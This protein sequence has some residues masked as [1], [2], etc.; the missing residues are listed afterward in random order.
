LRVGDVTPNRIRLLV[1]KSREGRDIVEHVPNGYSHFIRSGRH[2]PNF[3][4]PEMI[5]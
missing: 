3:R 5:I 1:R 4:F 2:A